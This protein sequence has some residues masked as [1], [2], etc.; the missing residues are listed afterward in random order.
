MNLKSLIFLVLTGLFITTG[1]AQR[2]FPPNSYNRLGVQGGVTYGNIH[3]KDFSFIDKLGY[4]AGLTTRATAG[5]N[6]FFI[7]GANFYEFNTGL[8]TLT[9]NSLEPEEIDFKTTGVQFNFFIGHKL[10]KEHLSFEMGPLLQINGKFTPEEGKENYSLKEYDLVASD[11]EE[12][13]R[14]NFS[15]AAGISGGFSKIKL[16]LQYQYGFSN[17]FNKLDY[18]E[19]REKDPTVPGLKGNMRMAAAGIVFYL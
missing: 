6:I 2:K 17:L 19:L 13:S 5:K 15:I 8:E 1:Y 11:L 4:T 12:I 7:Y 14:M 3:S 10:I 18:V 9:P 16:W